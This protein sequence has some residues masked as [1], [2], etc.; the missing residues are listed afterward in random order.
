VHVV[1]QPPAGGNHQA[2]AEE[3]IDLALELAG[4]RFDEHVEALIAEAKKDGARLALAA[5]ELATEGPARAGSVD[6]IAYFLLVEAFQKTSAAV[7]Q[8]S[9]DV[10]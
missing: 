7:E 2:V 10:A 5:A 8:P 1:F 3:L 9:L 6:Q 4:E